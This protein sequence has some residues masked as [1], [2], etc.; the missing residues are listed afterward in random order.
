M[1]TKSYQAQIGLTQRFR[2]KDKQ[3]HLWYSFFILLATS[4]VLP[5]L[6]AVL[7]TFVAGVMKEVW[8][9]YCGSG[10]CWYDMAA[11]AVGMTLALACVYLLNGLLI[12]GLEL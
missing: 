9:H 2:Q 5:L 11:N 3:K 6:A 12:F 4:F 8:D 1:R 10:F 7:L